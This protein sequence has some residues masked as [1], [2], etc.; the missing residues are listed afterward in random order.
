MVLFMVINFQIWVYN[1]NVCLFIDIALFYSYKFSNMGIQG[2]ESSLFAWNLKVLSAEGL[3]HTFL[4]LVVTLSY[5][6]L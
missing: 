3:K 4:A 6:N 5:K 2:N 1:E